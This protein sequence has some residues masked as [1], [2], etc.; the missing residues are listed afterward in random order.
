MSSLR[1]ASPCRSASFPAPSGTGLR[2]MAPETRCAIP[3]SSRFHDR[4]RRCDEPMRQAAT[5]RHADPI[6]LESPSATAGPGWRSAPPVPALVRPL[7][8]ESRLLAL[9]SLLPRAL[10]ACRNGGPDASQLSD[11]PERPAESLA[12]SAD[13]A[14]RKRHLPGISRMRGSKKRKR[15]LCGPRITRSHPR[16]EGA[17]IRQPGATPREFASPNPTVP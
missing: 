12:F 3:L 11:I 10:F 16:T 14:E 7:P 6:V 4:A 9:T 17:P 2:S 1:P 8:S 15:A 13:R 5:E